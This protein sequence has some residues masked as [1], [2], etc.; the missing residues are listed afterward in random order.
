MRSDWS[1]K[2]LNFSSA[3]GAKH[4]RLYERKLEALEGLKK[5]VLH[6]AFSGNL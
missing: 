4:E 1:A 5:S 6:Q 3:T 2:R